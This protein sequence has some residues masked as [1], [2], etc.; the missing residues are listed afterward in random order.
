MATLVTRKLKTVTCA[1]C[2]PSKQ[3]YLT[4]IKRATQK[5]KKKYCVNVCHCLAFGCVLVSCKW[6]QV[7]CMAEVFL[8]W[9]LAAAALC[10]TLSLS[11]SVCLCSYVCAVLHR[12]AIFTCK[13]FVSC[14]R[15]AVSVLLRCKHSGL[16]R[17]HP[18]DA[19]LAGDSRLSISLWHPRRSVPGFCLRDQHP[20]LH[21]VLAGG[22]HR[23][24]QRFSCWAQESV[25]QALLVSKRWVCRLHTVCLGRQTLIQ[26]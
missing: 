9:S 26:C 21:S 22:Q 7:G 6:R 3:V 4:S 15:R 24:C 25:G 23:Q 1:F 19:N 10:L 5:R 2:L 8:T 14:C 16:S 11:L 12:G 13:Y 17:H 18:G 20:K